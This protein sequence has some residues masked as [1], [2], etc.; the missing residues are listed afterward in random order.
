M[1][2]AGQVAT[3]GL[4]GQPLFMQA[5]RSGD[6]GRGG[7]AV[8]LDAFLAAVVFEQREYFQFS[9]QIGGKGHGDS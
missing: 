1:T 6:Q 7:V 2:Q 8:Y 9:D 3:I 4:I 5:L